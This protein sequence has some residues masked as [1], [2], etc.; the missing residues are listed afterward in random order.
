MT[1]LSRRILP[2]L[3]AATAI[4]IPLS[5]H[6]E[7]STDARAEARTAAIFDHLRDDPA[8]LAIF[9]RDFPKGADLHNHLS[10]AISAESYLR[11]AAE[12]GLCISSGQKRILPT[13]CPAKAAD[14]LPARALPQDADTT[15]T[16]IDALSMRDF[17]PT[18]N[19]RSGHDHFFAT[20]RR[21]DPATAHHHGDMLAEALENA[22]RDHV[23]YLELMVSPALGDILAAGKTVPFHGTDLPKARH[24]FA[25]QIP[26]L[27]AKAR[28]DL[29]SMEKRAHAVLHCGTPNARPG[30]NVT[31]R[32]L[33]QAIRIVPA[34]LV[35]S[36]LAVGYA[37]AHQD[38]RV[39]GL[40]FVAPEDN[41]VA[42]RDYDLHMRLFGAFAADYPDVSLSLH[43][44]ELSRALVPTRDLH[45]HIRKAIDIGGAE[46][47]GHGVDIGLEDDPPGLLRE[48]AR[49]KV[50]V[51][52]ALTS[53]AEILNVTGRAHPFGL[54]RKA[55]V[56]V[57]L[58]TDDEG[59]SRG[60][61]TQEYVKASQIWPLTYIDLKTLSRAG[62]IYGFVEG[63]SLWQNG[64]IVAACT[65]PDSATCRTFLKS[66]AKARLQR[67]LEE[68][69]TRFETHAP[70]EALYQ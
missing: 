21:F 16:L 50:L 68:D 41:P 69:F 36:Q 8:R 59:V 52:I 65:Q 40:N 56:P 64:H 9:L 10:G 46:R 58:V 37:L 6:A 54:Y 18:A 23:L 32:Y 27:V 53:N 11:W 63:A 12:D 70:E 42:L 5:A 47:I 39:V 15:N 3:C 31:L 30:C 33:F 13:P 2:F 24:A 61:L 20:F 17:T 44:G 51:E 28:A 48:M 57:T 22:A 1:P 38:A 49:K 29:D 60:D 45:D 14:T 43:A 4:L 26:A 62:L 7:T 66:S 25:P 67:R 19:D 34:P 35:V 55:G